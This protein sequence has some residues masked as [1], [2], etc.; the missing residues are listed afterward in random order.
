MI[1]EYAHIIDRL[2]DIYLSLTKL[3][4]INKSIQNRYIVHV[5]LLAKVNK[6]ILQRKNTTNSLRLPK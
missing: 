6:A 4:R 3:H 5:I 2:I 1:S